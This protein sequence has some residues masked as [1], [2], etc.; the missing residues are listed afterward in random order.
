MSEKKSIF[1]FH[2]ADMMS[3]WYYFVLR[4]QISSASNQLA[5]L[6]GNYF[7]SHTPKLIIHICGFYRISE[8]MVFFF[9]TKSKHTYEMQIDVGFSIIMQQQS[10]FQAF[11]ACHLNHQL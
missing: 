5:H 4:A 11:I 1:P 9:S 7:E 8:P 6:N 10:D 2:A 3:V